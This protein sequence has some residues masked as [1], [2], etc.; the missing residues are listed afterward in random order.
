LTGMRSLDTQTRQATNDVLDSREKKGGLFRTAAIKLGNWLRTGSK[1]GKWAKAGGTG[2]GVGTGVALLATVGG[3]GWPISS[4]LA[5]GASLAVRTSVKTASLDAMRKAE[6]HEGVMTDAVYNELSA[7]PGSTAE[8]YKATAQTIAQRIFDA[9]REKGYSQVDRANKEVAGVMGKY[10]IAMLAG[11]SVTAGIHHLM[12]NDVPVKGIGKDPIPKDPKPGGTIHG[13][14]DRLFDVQSGSGYV[15][16]L[17]E[18]VGAN[19]QHLTA[20]QSDSLHHALMDKFGKDYIDIR[21]V[22]KDIYTQAGD[23]RLS[24]PGKATWQKGV[25]EF[26]QQWMQN[27]GIW[28]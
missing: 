9:S 8:S 7:Q 25:A 5:G 17:R 10:G 20:S 21:G 12:Q 15:R 16:E 13:L 6:N 27:K 11:A 23:V 19:G 4:A 14:K 18:F 28:K 3:V 22:G 1:I 24:A 26:T 2:A